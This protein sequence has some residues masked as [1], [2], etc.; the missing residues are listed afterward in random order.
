[1]CDDL[2]RQWDRLNDRYKALKKLYPEKDE[3]AQWYDENLQKILRQIPHPA[4]G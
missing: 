3:L 4:G 2:E 1:M